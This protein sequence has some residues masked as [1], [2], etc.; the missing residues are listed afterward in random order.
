MQTIMASRNLGEDEARK[1]L[2]HTDANRAAYIKQMG[3]G[4][5]PLLVEQRL[6]LR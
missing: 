1:L 3:A 5:A 6:V 4:V 2:K